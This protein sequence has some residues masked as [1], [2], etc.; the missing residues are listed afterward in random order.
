ME[1]YDGTEWAQAVK[2]GCA[3]ILAVPSI[4]KDYVYSTQML[5]GMCARI[6]SNAHAVVPEETPKMLGL[7]AAASQMNHSCSPNTTFSGGLNGPT[8]YCR[9]LTAIPRGASLTISYV[10]LYQPRKERRELLQNSK[11]F[12]CQCERCALPL[13]ESV[14]AQVEGFTCPLKGCKDGMLVAQEGLFAPASLSTFGSQAAKKSGGGKS[15]KK[16]AA[17]ATKSVEKDGDDEE[18]GVK[19]HKCNKCEKLVATDAVDKKLMLVVFQY[20]SA[21]EL[22]GA[23]GASNT[24][25]AKKEYENILSHHCAPQSSGIGIS[26]ANGASLP[27]ASASSLQLAEHHWIAFSTAQKLM[28][29]CIRLGDVMGAIRALKRVANSAHRVLPSNEPETASYYYALAEC[30]VQ[31]EQQGKLGKLG[32]QSYLELK[33]SAAKTALEMRTLSL[34]AQHPLTLRCSSLLTAKPSK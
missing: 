10:D 8:L 9:A 28:N 2:K 34:G 5:L 15:K 1:Y 25:K 20:S 24:E 23:G 27:C 29:C 19:A 17:K 31:L 6:N 33:R 30:V 3:S 14:D 16:P 22:Y 4:P 12:A 32:I 7:F 21:S 18:E 11:F 26:A 13:A